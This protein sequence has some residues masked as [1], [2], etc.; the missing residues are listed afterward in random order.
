MSA[1]GR[2]LGLVPSYAKIA[3]WGMIAPRVRGGGPLIVSQAVVVDEGRVL[4]S[5]RADLRG[6]EL[7]GGN[8]EPGESEEECLRR[9]VLEETGFAVVVERHVGDYVR[10]GLLP[11][12]ARVYR[13]RVAGGSLRPSHETPRVR[14]F[15]PDEIPGTLLPWYREPLADALAD[16][17]EPVLRRERQ[18]LGAVLESAWI[19]LKMRL[20]NHRA[21]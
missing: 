13:C 16:A 5:V 15:A 19:D 14:W 1:V 2:F 3:W 9:E 21:R 6:W 17:R 20:T 7:P 10:S 11:H 8:V 4:L 18:G 12:V